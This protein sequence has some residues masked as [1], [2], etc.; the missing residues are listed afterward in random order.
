MGDVEHLPHLGVDGGVFGIGRRTD[1]TQLRRRP[2]ILGG[3][4][5]DVDA[6]RHQ[7]L[8]QQAR[9]QLP[10]TVMARRRAPG[11]RRQHGDAQAIVLP[12]FP[13][14]SRE[15]HTF[16]SPERRAP[17]IDL[18]RIVDSGQERPVIA[19]PVRQ[20][21]AQCRPPRLSATISR[22]APCRRSY[23]STSPS[24][25]S[26]A[27]SPIDSARCDAPGRQQPT[28]ECQD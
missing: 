5:R 26:D 9:H 24:A 11:D 2:A 23:A 14:N 22:S 13:L 20:L 12:C 7:R 1:T 18:P 15:D 3:E 25:S 6:A 4:Q 17:S 28:I 19:R 16:I 27:K 8:G 21:Q 10:G